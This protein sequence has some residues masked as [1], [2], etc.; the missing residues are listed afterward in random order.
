MVRIR[1]WLVRTGPMT[2]IKTALKDQPLSAFIR[3]NY[4]IFLIFA[5]GF[6]LRIYNIGG[7]SIWY[8]EAIS[9]AVAKLGFVEHLRW[10]AEV[11]DNNPPLYYTLLH[12]WIP[13]F[14]DSEASVRMLS[15]VFG[16]LS[17]L[18]IYALGKL[19]FDKK[20]GLLA[21]SILAVSIFGIMFSQEA[22]AYSL[23]AFLALLSF[24]FLLRLTMSKS[25]VYAAAYVIS[26]VCLLYSHYYGIF[27]VLAQN[28][29]FFTELALKRR[30]GNLGLLKW[31]FLQ[32][33]IVVLF[34]PSS[35]LLARNTAAIKKGFWITEPTL[36]DILGYFTLYAG[37]SFLLCVFLFFTLLAVAGPGLI[38]RINLPER[39]YG[40]EDYNQEG[41]GISYGSRIYLLL[42]WIFAVVFIPFILSYLSS[43]ILIYRY[44]IAAA[45]AFYMLTARGISGLRLNMAIV[46]VVALIAGL[47]IPGLYRYYVETEKYDWREAARYIQ[48]EAGHGDF[49]VTY[50]KFE[51]KPAAYYLKRNDLRLEQFSEEFFTY[52]GIGDNNVWLVVS[53]HRGLEK[54]IM[55][56]KMTS[57]FDY[58]SETEYNGLHVYKFR[59]K[60][61]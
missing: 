17:I 9:V 52:T 3:E 50:P 49:V 29:W 31:I 61:E 15:A 48:E 11:D 25:R 1:A 23:M 4:L 21:A 22:R 59:A 32:G 28:I 54:N 47:S 41:A 58:V 53:S 43:P 60:A 7:E 36:N 51:V 42:A 20:T 56:L 10:I 46:L 14:G 8:D 26:S 2:K 35:F 27:V 19:L 5:A 30:V 13:I 24:Y 34:L 18:V 45:P 33:L 55:K 44:T 40:L 16:S 6:A 38:K 12:L 57:R 37:A 39:F